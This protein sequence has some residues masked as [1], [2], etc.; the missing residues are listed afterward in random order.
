MNLK[1]SWIKKREVSRKETPLIRNTK[2]PRYEGI[3]MAGNSDE[4]INEHSIH[5]VMVL[6]KRARISIIQCTRITFVYDR[7]TS[8][9]I[10]KWIKN[11]DNW[12]QCRRSGS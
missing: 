3:K 10:L 4:V 8:F 1:N 11:E 6:E 9:D 7:L 5:G 12:V 2:C